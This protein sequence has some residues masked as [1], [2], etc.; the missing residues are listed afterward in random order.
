MHIRARRGGFLLR[1]MKVAVPLPASLAVVISASLLTIL[2]LGCA[3]KETRRLPPSQIAPLLE[4]SLE[5]LLGRIQDLHDTIRSINTRVELI[6]TTGSAYS[7]IIEEY[8]DVRAFILAQR[9][10]DDVANGTHIRVIGQAPVVRKNI[11]DM[12]ADEEGFRIYIPSKNKFVVGGPGLEARSEKPIENLRPQHLVEA[13][14]VAPPQASSIHLLE[15]NEIGGTRYYVVSELA[16]YGQGELAWQRKWWFRRS[17]LSLTRVQGFGRRGQLIADI[18]YE[19]WTQ[20]GELHY[21]HW[22]LLVRPQEDY[23]LELRVEKL[24]LNEKIE[25]EKFE[26]KKP[27]EAELVD[28]S[29]PQREAGAAAPPM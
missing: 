10:A 3:V 4:A 20:H 8:H 26:L 15:E 27:A 25:A 18:H 28:L 14:F 17:N 21:P 9:T 19:V 1:K 13:L 23:R 2:L 29:K 7:G 24:E 12:V 11:F 22:I 16:A 6:P 5:E